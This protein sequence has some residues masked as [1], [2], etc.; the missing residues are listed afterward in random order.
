MDAKFFIVMG[1]AGCGKSTI[2]EQLAVRLGW[3]F[4]EG[5][6][7]HPPGNIEKMTHGVPLTDADRLPWLQAIAKRIAE[8]RDGGKSGVVTCSA[9]R[10]SYRKIITDGFPD[11]CF[12]YLRADR[13]LIA[14][15]FAER[16]GHFMPASLI[17][18]QF[19]TL[20]EPKPDENALTLDVAE[21]VS[22][23]VEIVA[24]VVGDS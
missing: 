10:D 3:P 13:A 19:E 12:I 14:Q 16:R 9:L 4:L 11:V 24:R 6:Q 17:A 21:P 7:L 5:D 2:G 22:I 23:L 1:V 20:E 8:W 15:R 18:S